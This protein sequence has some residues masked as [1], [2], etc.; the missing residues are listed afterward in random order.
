[1]SGRNAAQESQAGEGKEQDG[2]D[3]PI[4]SSVAEL[5]SGAQVSGGWVAKGPPAID[6]HDTE[7]P[8]AR[9]PTTRAVMPPP[10]GDF[11][12]GLLEAALAGRPLSEP[13][14]SSSI[15]SSRP[16]QSSPPQTQRAA[17]RSVAP[18]SIRVISNGPFSIIP[19]E[20]PASRYAPAAGTPEAAPEDG[21]TFSD[22]LVTLLQKLGVDSAFGL[23][24][25]AVAHFCAALVR[26]NMKVLHFRHEAG[27]VFA[28]LESYYVKDRPACVFTTTGPG[29]TNAITGIAA[30]RRDGAKL[31]V[32]SGMTAAPQ[33]GRWAFQE[34]SAYT[35]PLSGLFTAGP[36]FHFA[37]TI[38]QPVE[39][40][41]AYRR[42]ASGLQK[43]GGFVAHLSLP[44]TSQ[45][46]QDFETFNGGPI[47]MLPLRSAEATASE[48]AQLLKGESYA[49][50]VGFGARRA[51]NKVRELARRTGAAVMC[52]PR[53]KGIF[54]ESH[55][56][57]VGVTGFGGHDSVFEYMSKNR[58]SYILVLGTRLGEFTSFWSEDMVPTKGFIHVDVDPEAA[59]VAY[60]DVNTIAVQAEIGSF[61]DALLRHFPRREPAQRYRRSFAPPPSI[62]PRATGPVRPDFLMQT[63]QRVIV[64]GTDAP[65]IT[66][67]GNAFAWGTHSLHFEEAGRYRV[68]TGFGSMGHAVTGVLGMALARAGKAVA[69]AGDGAMLMNSEISTAVQYDIPAVWIV[70]NDSAYGMIEQ[71]LNALKLPSVETQMPSTDFVMI[72]RGMG[73]DGVRVERE[74]DLEA[75]LEQAMKA[76]GPFVVDVVIDP[77]VRAPAGRRFKSLVEDQFA[78]EDA[79]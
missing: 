51:V 79:D 17:R 23:T 65:V 28:A 25:G 48:C 41:E 6:H 40:C 45:V 47:S 14:P 22:Y 30:A 31:I 56:Q 50:W 63:I 55:P 46:T 52:S 64:E 42:I 9:K 66:E 67:A 3:A 38:E 15:P 70:L 76:A 29:L 43:P 62:A 74:E 59:G 10:A 72:A 69:L 61:L 71:G 37:A 75:A 11:D 24:G 19:Q 39:L 58:P 20:G 33:R 44:L 7:P 49:I 4:S 73:A 8:P 5:Y 36:L 27:A 18:P 12:S 54:P 78:A 35:M 34:T 21:S 13:P 2:S 1:M 16:P 26:A 68:S 57:F 60:P 53:A 32:I 77:S